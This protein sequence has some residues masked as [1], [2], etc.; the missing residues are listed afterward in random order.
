MGWHSYRLSEKYKK[1]FFELT[2]VSVI[3]F[4]INSLGK[5]HADAF[6]TLEHTPSK[7]ENCTHL[8]WAHIAQSANASLRA[9]KGCT[10][11]VYYQALL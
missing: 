6:I 11:L 7:L 5:M 4:I 8:S 3:R 2:I 1:S 9:M 10:S